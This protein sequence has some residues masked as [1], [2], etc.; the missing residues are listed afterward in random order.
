MAFRRLKARARTQLHDR[1]RVETLFYADGPDGPSLTVWPRVNS[2]VDAAGDLQGTSLSY[3]E[4]AEVQPKLIFL[5]VDHAPSKH[6]VYI[7]SAVEGYEVT[8]LEPPDGVTTSAI[9]APLSKTQLA[10]YT[11]PGGC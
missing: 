7:M 6:D 5:R 10:L 9:C 8:H 4:T 1:M 3:A 2:K 11:P